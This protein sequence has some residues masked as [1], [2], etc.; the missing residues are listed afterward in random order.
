MAP[1]APLSYSMH[2]I[3]WNYRMQSC[4]RGIRGNCAGAVAA[5][6]AAA[7]TRKTIIFRDPLPVAQALR[8]SVAVA[9]ASATVPRSN[10]TRTFVLRSSLPRKLKRPIQYGSSLSCA[11]T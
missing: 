1:L 9:V 3:A 4:Y 8:G 6:A 7:V 11:E 5:A 10:S 2:R